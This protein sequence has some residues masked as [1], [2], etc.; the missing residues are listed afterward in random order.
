MKRVNNFL[1]EMENIIKK[2]FESNNTKHPD[3][4]LRTY[5]T[6][7]NNI[8][9]YFDVSLCGAEFWM[10]EVTYRCLYNEFIVY[11]YKLEDN[12]SVHG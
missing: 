3:I 12:Y 8:D 1:E 2:D 11:A 10:Y 5:T 7:N 4:Y 6:L 9:A